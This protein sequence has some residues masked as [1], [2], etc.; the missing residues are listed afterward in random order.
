MCLA[1]DNLI[2]DLDLSETN[3]PMGSQLAIGP[4]VVVEISDLS[5]TGC[6]KFAG[7]YGPEAREFTNDA[8]GKSLHLRGRYARV[9]H[10]GIISIGET[11]R[12]WV[13]T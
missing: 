7:R 5:H 1:G 4:E 2:V 13:S 6:S 12:K 3:L 9:V 11:V 10:G 8:R